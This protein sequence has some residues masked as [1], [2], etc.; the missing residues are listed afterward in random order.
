[1]GVY[2]YDCVYVCIFFSHNSPRTEA[3]V[4]SELSVCDFFFREKK[5]N[6]LFYLTLIFI[7]VSAVVCSDLRSLNLTGVHGPLKHRPPPPPVPALLI[8]M[9]C[10]TP[11]SERSPF[12]SPDP[13][14]LSLRGFMCF[15]FIRKDPWSR[16]S[17]KLIRASKKNIQCF[18]CVI[19]FFSLSP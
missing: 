18:P 4:E 6:E 5:K 2:W 13:A 16:H 10:Q 14:S 8:S 1:M 15:C 3:G 12:I 19:F 17:L 7:A 9:S 11:L